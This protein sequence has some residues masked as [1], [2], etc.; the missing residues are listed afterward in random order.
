MIAH[1]E[2]IA[3]TPNTIDVSW[4]ADVL[5]K[6]GVNMEKSLPSLETNVNASAGEATI[7]ANVLPSSIYSIHV[8]DAD[9]SGFEYSMG[10]ITP[11]YLG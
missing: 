1:F 6:H 8:K 7:S 4:D 9:K 2:V 10:E 11:S 3:T 5:S